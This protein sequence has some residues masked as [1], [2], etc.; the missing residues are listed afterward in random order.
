MDFFVSNLAPIMF[1]NLIVFLLFGF[2]VA[3][4]LAGTGILYGV[5]DIN[6]GLI[7]PALLQ[8]LP[9]RDLGII[10]NESLLAV[11]FFTLLGLVLERSRFDEDFLDT[12]WMVF[13]LWLGG[14]GIHVG[15]VGAI[16]LGSTGV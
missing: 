9:Q 5:V 4:S 15:V 13:G 1:A 3:F 10:S 14:F 6:L 16:L 11:P 7:H 8:A 12:I 2:P